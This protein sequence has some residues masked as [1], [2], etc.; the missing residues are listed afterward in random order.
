MGTNTVIIAS[1]DFST[2]RHLTVG[3]RVPTHGFSSC[4]IVPRTGEELMVAIKSEEIEG[5]VATTMMAFTIGVEV[6]ME[7]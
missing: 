3:E 5:R 6:I 7:E 1:E 2:I 4:K